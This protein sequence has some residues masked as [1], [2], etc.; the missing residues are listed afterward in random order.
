MTKNKFLGIP[1]FF[2]V[3]RRP[4]KNEAE[5]SDEKRATGQERERRVLIC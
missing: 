5:E 3:G 4:Q 1:P 2:S